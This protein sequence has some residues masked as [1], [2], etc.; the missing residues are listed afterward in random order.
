M[1]TIFSTKQ[2]LFVC[3]RCRISINLWQ[4]VPIVVCILWNV[5]LHNVPPNTS[6]VFYGILCSSMTEIM[7]WLCVFLHR[8]E[9]ILST[10]TQQGRQTHDWLRPRS[11]FKTKQPMQALGCVLLCSAKVKIEESRKNETSSLNKPSG[12]GWSS[13]PVLKHENCKVMKIF[14]S[15][16]SA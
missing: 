5:N 11:I 1:V 2:R 9:A 10:C 15:K 4:N 3:S 12:S 13:G 6:L 14:P 8:T 16:S 7:S